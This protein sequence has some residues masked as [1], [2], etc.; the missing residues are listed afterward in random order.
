MSQDRPLL[1]ITLMLGFCLLAPFADALAKLLG[2][3]M[4]V[5]QLVTLRFAFQALILVPLTLA[6]GR[7]WRMD[8]RVLVFVALRTLLH[9]AGI[10]LVF[11]ALLYLPLA[12]AIAI[13]YVM[14]FILL[15]LG[16]LFL[17]EEVGWRRLAACAVG[18]GGTLLVIQPAFEDVGW[19]ALL[20]LGV[21]LVFALFML[22]TRRIAHVTDPV[23][24]Q[25]VSALMA[26]ALMIPVMALTPAGSVGAFDWVAPSARGW[27]LITLMGC[28]G[29]AAHL[30]MTWSLRYAPAATLA[31]MQYLEIP[32]A[33]LVGYLI[34]ADLPGPLAA[35]GI[36]IT[37]GSGL[38]IVMRERAIGAVPP[39][40]PQAT[41]SGTPPAT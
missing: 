33:T 26:L 13:A 25:A 14:P 5:G 19:P 31:P 21:A 8:G 34:F 35:L 40:A 17:D 1:G 41:H 4:A 20:P 15:L 27:W 11:T 28:A 12:D 39:P 36:A 29:T 38:Y 18:F 37:M 22:V 16:K 23:G 24:M 6:T 7:A 3:E 32:F 2:P 10:T 9:I 30:L